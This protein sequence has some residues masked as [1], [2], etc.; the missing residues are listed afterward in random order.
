MSIRQ[1]SDESSNNNRDC[2]NSI[3]SIGIIRGVFRP[4]KDPFLEEKYHHWIEESAKMI[5]PY[6]H[7]I[8]ETEQ[9]FLQQCDAI[10]MD[11]GDNRMKSYQYS[12][13]M[14]H[15]LKNRLSDFSLD[16]NDETMEKWDREQYDIR[17]EIM[18]TLPEHY[19]IKAAGYYLPKTE[20][21]LYLYDEF[22]EDIKRITKS[23]EDINLNTFCKDICF[24][25]EETTEDIQC[26]NGGR[27]LLNK[28]IVYRGVSDEDIQMRNAR[29]QG[30]LAS[31]QE[32]GNLPDFR[33]TDGI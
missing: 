12:V 20:R 31:M 5:Q 6:S 33:Q 2:N 26:N 16:I 10:P 25:F 22:T 1:N 13:I 9:Y 19:G 23:K 17:R 30:Y 27:S 29:F 28:L 7:T 11:N 18:N 3:S 8:A 4:D 32:L 14:K 15:K 21:N 24:F